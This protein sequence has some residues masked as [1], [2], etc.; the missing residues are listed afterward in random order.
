MSQTPAD[1]L[2]GVLRARGVE[3]TATSDM[4]LSGPKSL[5]IHICADP[6]PGISAYWDSGEAFWSPRLSRPADY[7]QFLDDIVEGIA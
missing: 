5:E 4:D 2:A 1:Q 7:Y 3:A 6:I